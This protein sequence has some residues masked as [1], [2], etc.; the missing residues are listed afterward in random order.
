MLARSSSSSLIVSVETSNIWL[1]RIQGVIPGIFII[2]GTRGLLKM[3]KRR[4]GIDSTE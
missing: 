1:D 4:N 3:L 2:G